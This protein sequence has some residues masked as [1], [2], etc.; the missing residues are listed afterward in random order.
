MATLSY[1][2]ARGSAPLPVQHPGP[3]SSSLCQRQSGETGP[4]FGSYS[5][6]SRPIAR[7]DRAHALWRDPFRPSSMSLSRTEALD[8]IEGSFYLDQCV[9]FDGN[10]KRSLRHT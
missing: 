4:Q 2:A 3:G 5:G 10:P 8:V 1:C 6:C 9:D 7:L